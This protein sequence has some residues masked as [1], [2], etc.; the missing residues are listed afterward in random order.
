MG[1]AGAGAGQRIGDVGPGIDMTATA[2]LNDGEGGGVGSAGRVNPSQGT[3]LRV[4]GYFVM[5]EL[6]MFAVNVLSRLFRARVR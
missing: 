4:N 2:C 3:L 5:V 6:S 1:E